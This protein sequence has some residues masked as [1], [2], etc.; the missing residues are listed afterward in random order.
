MK[1]TSFLALGTAAILHLSIGTASAQLVGVGVAVN[2]NTPTLF[3]VNQTTGEATPIGPLGSATAQP[4]GLA[5]AGGN[6]YTFD[7]STDTVRRIDPF[8]GAFTGAN[9]RCES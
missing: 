7:A 1:R 9:P 5:T 6:L 2:T 8:T 3:N 4:Y